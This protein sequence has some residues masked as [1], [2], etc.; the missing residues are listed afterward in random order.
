MLCWGGAPDPDHDLGTRDERGDQLAAADPAILCD[1]QSGRQQ[2]GARMHAGARPGE[3][4][5][6]EGVRE[7]AVCQRRR[8][9]M[10]EHAAGTE[11]AAGAAG[12]MALGK[13]DDDAA[14]GQSV[15]ENDGGD[16]IGDAVLGALNNV[17]RNVV[18]AQRSR[19]FG[20]S[21]GL[22]PHPERSDAPT[23]GGLSFSSLGGPGRACH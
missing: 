2:N 11:N 14:P 6:L 19:V 3:I 18:I 4:V 8:R 15:S 17:G 23:A 13:A 5:H 12:A 21:R 9:R 7:R 22:V 10:D 16:G 20:Q 1:C